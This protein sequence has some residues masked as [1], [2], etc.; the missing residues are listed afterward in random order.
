MVILVLN[1]DPWKKHLWKQS[2]KSN[3]STNS[4]RPRWFVCLLAGELKKELMDSDE[5][6]QVDR[7]QQEEQSVSDSGFLKDSSTLRRRAKLCIVFRP[8]CRRWLTRN[9]LKTILFVTNLHLLNWIVSEIIAPPFF[10]GEL[11][12]NYRQIQQIRLCL[13]DSNRLLDPEEEECLWHQRDSKY[14]CLKKVLLS[15]GGDLKYCFCTK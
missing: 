14:L 12:P 6:C 5:T 8:Y 13:T 2:V 9:L 15:C 10:A 3:S 4:S 1:P 11:Q 7:T